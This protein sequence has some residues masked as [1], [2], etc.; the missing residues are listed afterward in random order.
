MNDV[1]MVMRH[2]GFVFIPFFDKGSKPTPPLNPSCRKLSVFKGVFFIVKDLF[3]KLRTSFVFYYD[4][5]DLLEDQSFE[6]KGR[7]IDAVSKLHLNGED[8][9]DEMPEGIKMLFKQM[10]KQFERDGEKY[11]AVIE[12]RRNAGIKSGES[13]LA[14]ASNSSKCYDLPKIENAPVAIAKTAKVAKEDVLKYGEHQ[15]VKLT[16]KQYETSLKHYG[17]NEERLNHAIQILDDY[18]E[19]NPKKAYAN[20]SL[21]LKNWVKE[22]VIKKHGWLDV[23]VDHD[24]HEILVMFENC[25]SVHE[26]DFIK[27]GL[28]KFPI[29]TQKQAYETWASFETGK[30]FCAMLDT[31][32]RT[33]IENK[34]QYALR[35]INDHTRLDYA[36]K[37]YKGDFKP[38]NPVIRM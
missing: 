29:P 20:H 2:F 38:N 23:E 37:K 32:N 12:K 14:K 1:I 5:L 26:V 17:G 4:W 27:E 11:N 9:T 8:V 35:L 3:V 25:D 31:F 30:R 10:K 24:R 15:R 13:R 34:F 16:E 7:L 33:D 28:A 19:I 36:I 22:E 18:L 6:N 21:V